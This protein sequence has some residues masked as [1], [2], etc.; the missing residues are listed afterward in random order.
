MKLDPVFTVKENK[1]YKI[2]DDSQVEVNSLK[3]VEIKWSVI[4]LEPETYNEEYLAN[5]REELKPLDDTGKYVYLSPVVDKALNTPEDI[6]LYINAINHCARRIKDCTCIAGIELPEELLL[7]G[8]E[9]GTPVSDFMETLAK[10]HAQ[11]VYFASTDNANKA[12]I[13]D[14]VQNLAIVIY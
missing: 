14:K 6:E 11:Y 12:N 5:L 8:I 2:A 10:K 1:L 4:E 9:E 3:K 7:K 13:T